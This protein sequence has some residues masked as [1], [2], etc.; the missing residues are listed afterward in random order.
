VETDQLVK[1]GAGGRYSLQNK[2]RD[3]VQNLSSGSGSLSSGSAG[4]GVLETLG[5][6]NCTDMTRT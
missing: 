3:F 5:G 4:G 6:A 1:I 2:Q